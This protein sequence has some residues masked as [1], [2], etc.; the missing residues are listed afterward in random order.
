MHVSCACVYFYFVDVFTLVFVWVC[1]LAVC[2]FSSPDNRWNNQMFM[3]CKMAIGSSGDPVCACVN[4]LCL[5]LCVVVWV[6]VRATLSNTRLLVTTLCTERWSRGNT[7]SVSQQRQ[8]ERQSS[9]SEKYA[10]DF[11]LLPH[12]Q[13]QTHTRTHAHTT[14]VQDYLSNL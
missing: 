8:G 11:F 13:M 6:C 12:T 5:C 14:K 2:V 4:V 3:M 1:V 10:Y 7:G 9:E